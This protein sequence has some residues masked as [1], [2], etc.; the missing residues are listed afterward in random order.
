MQTILTS[1]SDWSKAMKQV[2]FS[3]AKAQLSELIDE[4]E[5][6]ETVVI[7]RHGKPIV[8]LMREEDGRRAQALV[9]MAKIKELRKQTKSATIEEILAW[10]DEG[11]K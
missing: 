6:G 2:Q 10:R 1:Q 3:T 5:R 7:T 9:A 8:R 11:R 4:V